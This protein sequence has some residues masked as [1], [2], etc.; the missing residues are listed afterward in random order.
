MHVY[1]F[2]I[3]KHLVSHPSPISS[4]RIKKEF[5]FPFHL[6]FRFLF[7]KKGIL[8]FFWF[9]HKVL[10]NPLLREYPS[11]SYLFENSAGCSFF[12][13]NVARLVVPELEATLDGIVED[14][15]KYF[16]TLWRFY[17]SF[18]RSF[19]RRCDPR[20]VVSI[21]AI[22]C[23][24]VLEILSGIVYICSCMGHHICWLKQPDF[25]LLETTV[26][27]VT[28][29]GWSIRTLELRRK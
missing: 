26:K 6:P 22:I 20:K 17:S 19:T 13:E 16:E 27:S 3:A 29:L 18:H 23:Y 24:G 4:T 5:G 1:L 2:C 8:F 10:A 21:A 9:L 25:F 14:P 7:K 11:E 28:F 12:C 15:L